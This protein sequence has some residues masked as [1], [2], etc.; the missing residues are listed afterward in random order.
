[1]YKFSEMN[2]LLI[3]QAE[4]L[5]NFESSESSNTEV[6]LKPI[7]NFKESDGQSQS[8]SHA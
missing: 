7:G 4:W 5:Q 1:M 2:F 6:K 3:S 8:D